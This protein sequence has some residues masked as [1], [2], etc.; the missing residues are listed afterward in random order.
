M[1]DIS[2]SI[3]LPVFNEE[4]SI[5]KVLKSIF[6]FMPLVANDF[7]IIAVDDGS[8]D[9]TNSI[10]RRLSQ[11]IPCIRVIHHSKNMGYGATLISGFKIARYPLLFFMDSDGQFDISEITKLIPYIEQFDIVVG[12]K[13]GRQDSLH[14]I[15]I[16]RIYNF[17]I[18]LL[19][20]IRMTDITCGFKLVKRTIFDK[21]NLESRSGFINAEILIKAKMLGYFIKEVAISHFPRRG[22]RQTGAGLR[23]IK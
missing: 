20:G 19:F 4:E 12:N 5:E 6:D 23:A 15:L 8:T 14:R 10:I 1:R 3:V 7:E 22:G 21:I 18:C 17:L 16:G 11:N 2:L 13:I 9:R